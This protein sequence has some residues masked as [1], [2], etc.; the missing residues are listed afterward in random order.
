MGFTN[1]I[2]PPLKQTRHKLFLS[3]EYNS[4]LAGEEEAKFSLVGFAEDRDMNN[5][6]PLPPSW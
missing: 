6:R 5:N 4:V 3:K 1:P 2:F